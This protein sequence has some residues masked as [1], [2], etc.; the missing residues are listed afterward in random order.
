MNVTFVGIGMEQLSVSLLASIAKSRGHKVSLAFSR[1][2]FQDRYNLNMPF[3]ARQF[4]DRK[5]L[6]DTIVQSEPDVLACSVLTSTYHWALEIAASAKE[7]I[8]GLKVVFG[9]VHPSS[10][11]EQVIARKEV[12]AICIGEGDEPFPALLDAYANDNFNDPIPNIFYK[13]E[14]G[15]QIRGAVGW[16]APDL[17]GLPIFDKGLWGKYIN[18]GDLYLTM[19]S[20]GCPFQCSFCF[21]SFYRDLGRSSGVPYVRSRSTD[22]VMEELTEAKKRYL[23]CCITFEDDAFT[24]DKD[25]L[26]ELLERYRSRIGVPFQCMAHSRLIDDE[27]ISLLSNAGCTWVE[28]GV[29]SAD[30]KYKKEQIGRNEGNERIQDLIGKFQ[31]AGIKVKCDHIFG[32]PGEPIESQEAARKLYVQTTPN[33]ITT[34]WATYLPATKMVRIGLDCGDLT[35]DDA[36]AIDAGEYESLLHPDSNVEDT[37]RV[38]LLSN[39][40][41]LF[42]LLPVLPIALR[43]SIKLRHIKWMPQTM[44]GMLGFWIDCI[45]GLVSGN[46]EHWAYIRQYFRFM[47]DWLLDKSRGI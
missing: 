39:Y 13:N 11:S 43:K 19:T 24:M 23:L 2:L 38:T 7:Q 28:M 42:R 32:M 21:N 12:D 22:H 3:L 35:D 47:K 34:Y 5:R 25:R 14:N 17:S 27:I 4:D 20:R 33:R 9:G 31:K 36:R 26:R 6:L 16:R 1:G 30:E 8:P 15:K 40:L 46:P 10:C 37:N 41:F 45:W 44:A 29:Q 18:V